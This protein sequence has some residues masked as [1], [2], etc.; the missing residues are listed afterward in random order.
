[1]TADGV[2][3]R[4]RE[5]AHGPGPSRV[6]PPKGDARTRGGVLETA[7]AGVTSETEVADGLERGRR[8][9]DQDPGAGEPGAHDREIAGVI[10]HSSLLTVGGL[11]FLV[12][13]QKPESGPGKK[14]RRPQS[15]Q[16]RTSGAGRLLP[17]RRFFALGEI[18]VVEGDGKPASGEGVAE[19]RPTGDRRSQDKNAPP[20]AE[21]RGDGLPVESRPRLD[22]SV[23]ENGKTAAFPREEIEKTLGR[24]RMSPCRRRP[25]IRRRRRTVVRRLEPSSLLARHPLVSASDPPKPRGENEA[26]EISGGDPVILGR[27]EDEFEDVR[28]PEGHVVEDPAHGPQPFRGGIVVPSSTGEEDPHPTRASERN[29]DAEARTCG[30]ES[31][32]RPEIGERSRSAPRK[33]DPHGRAAGRQ[34]G[35]RGVNRHGSEAL[36]WI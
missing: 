14:D 1:M 23:A 33:K 27:P 36:C 28:G 15:H 4:R 25:L 26:D 12:D 35:L 22:R 8:G 11:V 20:A 6:D 9:G 18:A 10:R 24:E 3:R 5:P 32:F 29:L 2:E 16:D 31:L 7:E 30:P 21:D 19:R 17:K 34:R 13:D